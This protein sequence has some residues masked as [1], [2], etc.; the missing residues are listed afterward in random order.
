MLTYDQFKTKALA[1]AGVRAEYERLERDE[2]PMLD[3]ILRA[4]AEA[5]LTQSQVAELMG[6]KAPAIARLE[7]ALVSGKPSPSIA[8]L[9]KYAAALGK[10][11]QF[12]FLP[13]SAPHL[14]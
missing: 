3:A 11:L 8:T 13:A 1:D 5:G 4:R 10:R 6:T 7:A 12:E 14:A 2:M 9:Q